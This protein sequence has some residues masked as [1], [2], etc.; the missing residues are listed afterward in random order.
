MLSKIERFKEWR[1]SKSDAEQQILESALLIF[2]YVNSVDNLD[3]IKANAQEKYNEF[4]QHGKRSWAT[5]VFVKLFIDEAIAQLPETAENEKVLLTQSSEVISALYENWKTNTT[6]NI[7]ALI[8][9][10]EKLLALNSVPFTD[11]NDYKT[12]LLSA[13]MLLHI[14]KLGI[15]EIERNWKAKM[16]LAVVIDLNQIKPKIDHFLLK[17]EERMTQLTQPDQLVNAA[18]SSAPDP[19]TPLKELFTKRYLKV[20]GVNPVTNTKPQRRKTGPL[21]FMRLAPTGPNLQTPGRNILESL[22]A[23]E[24]DM[25]KVSA[26]IFNLI[27]LRSKKSELE[28]KIEIVRAL[29]LAAKENDLKITGRQYFL[30]FIKGKEQSIHVLLENSEE[31]RKQK[32]IEKIKQ[33]K[34]MDESPALSSEVIQGVSWVATPITVVY[35]TA[36][37]QKLQD[38]IGSSLPATLDSLCKTEFKEMAK[39]CLLDLESK[40]RKK[41]QQIAT[42]NNRFFNQDEALKSFIA[43][44]SLERLAAF[45]KANE[46]M[47]E[48]VQTSY[49]LLAT[50][51]ENSLFLHGLQQ[52][53]QILS[54]FIRLHDG[55]FVK[56]SNF[57]AQYFSCF[58]TQTAKMIDD[59]ANLKIKVDGVVGKYREIVNQ[60]IG[61]IDRISSLDARI[62]L[63]IKNQFKAE[64][65]EIY[66]ERQNHSKPNRRTVSLLMKN[67][68]YLFTAK[69]QPLGEQKNIKEHDNEISGLGSVLL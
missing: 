47:K 56:I 61:Q 16:L 36:T 24:A 26:G 40:L 52:K 14:I 38:I 29:L 3:A 65:Y 15:A 60:G 67:L 35:R 55:F 46:E 6:K 5:A 44:E 20:I 30:E 34:D 41:E 37:P 13:G 68:S 18:Q 22:S 28:K 53:S 64:D 59:A 11:K 27:E 49:K 54:E 19:L 66:R 62:K 50:V 45:Q 4:D 17:I 69:P 57:L 7:F 43:D 42:I 1:G 31:H 9:N 58:K 51:K 32:L 10:I 48:A 25:E 21:G 63:H 12:F 23:L 33:L 2:D 39:L 8:G